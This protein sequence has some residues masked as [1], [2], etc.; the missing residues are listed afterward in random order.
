[1]NQFYIQ[2]TG[3]VTI[4]P[5]DLLLTSADRSRTVVVTICPDDLLLT[6]AD[7]R[8]KNIRV[9][10]LLCVCIQSLI[11]PPIKGW[12][13]TASELDLP[14]LKPLSVAGCSRP[15]LGVVH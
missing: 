14:S 13:I 10:L 1:M 8:R 5:D 11:S 9:E 3:V 15:H 6:S 2:R 4:C 7:R 12:S